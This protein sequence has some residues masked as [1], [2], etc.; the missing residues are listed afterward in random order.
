MCTT[1]VG[2]KHQVTIPKDVFEQL[3]LDVGD[4]LDV[5]VRGNTI[6]MVPAKLIPKEDAWFYTP[7]WQ[8][9]ERQAGEAIARGKVS[10]PFTSAKE[11]IAHLEK[12]PKRTRKT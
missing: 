3:R 5:Q 2:P 11:L 10:G 12:R 6:T 7:E 9:K 8:A 4:Y 1:K